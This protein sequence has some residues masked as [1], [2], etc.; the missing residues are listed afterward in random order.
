MSSPSVPTIKR[1]FALSGNQCAFPGCPLPMV[2]LSSGKVT[3][4]ICHI[5]ARQPGGPR[6]DSSQS[7]EERHSFRNLLLLCPIHHDVI[8]SD[9]DSYT[10]ERLLEIKSKHEDRQ[11]E[12]NE[13]DDQIATALITAIG[14][15]SIS[16]GSLLFGQN[17]SGG[18][19]ANQITNLLLQPDISAALERD[20]KTRRDTHDTEI[21]RRSDA[22]LNEAMLDQ[23]F[24]LLLGDHSY[25]ESFRSPIIIFCDFFD[26]IENEYLN[27]NLAPLTFE[28]T[29]ALKELLSFIAIHFFV[30]PESQR[31][32][33]TRYCLYPDLCIDRRGSGEPEEMSK[34]DKYT[35][36]LRQVVNKA[37]KAYVTYRRAIKQ[38][39]FL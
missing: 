4:R 26:K 10:V 14:S 35:E 21:F 30:F 12:G 39:L 20:L 15:N 18:Q 11:T 38:T 23:G 33:D 5:K 28:L 6:Y 2:D 37:S 19:M 1:L 3:G 34:Y 22:I 25:H 13:P 36:Q 7:D 27:S 29:V 31:Y 16:G 8:D 32:D 24:S 9:P 17:Q